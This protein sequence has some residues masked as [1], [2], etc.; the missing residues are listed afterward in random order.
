[1]VYNRPE[2][3]RIGV[4]GM[5]WHDIVSWVFVLAL[6]VLLLKVMPRLGGG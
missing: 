5:D 4:I 6:G 3:F 1:M 2:I